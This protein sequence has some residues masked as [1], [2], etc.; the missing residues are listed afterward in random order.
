MPVRL[1]ALFV[2]F[3]MAASSVRAAPD[4]ARAEEIIEQGTNQFRV[5]QG[6][7]RVAPN[8]AL[9]RA[10][11]GHAEFMART[12]KYGHEADGS[13]AGERARRA[14]FNHCLASENIAY[15]HSTGDFATAELANRYVEG[16]K[17]S[18]G[19]RRNMLEPAVTDFGVAV[20]RS[21]RTGRYYAV[22]V[23]ARPQSRAHKFRITNLARRS[24]D[25]TID[26]RRFSVGPG[27]ARI[28]TVC[29]PED[30]VFP[31]AENGKGRTIRPSAGDHLVV[32]G[33]A[34]I[35][36]RSER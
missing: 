26:A 36:V 32:R 23:F 14:G 8:A 11:R 5:E 12:D 3:G 4:L 18:P 6:L 20:S 9:E 35:T 7:P 31:A 13:N 34:R 29:A 16:W 19:H 28:H 22:Q 33:D 17:D 27:E 24:A 10:A 2:A 25:Y 15:Q 1:S 21:A 30:V